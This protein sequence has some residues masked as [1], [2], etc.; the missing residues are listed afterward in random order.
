VSRGEALK[1]VAV[2]SPPAAPATPIR[3]RLD[4]CAMSPEGGA[5]SPQCAECGALW[6]PVDEDRWEAFLTDDKPPE[7]A[8][9]CPKCAEREFR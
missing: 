6:P 1:R 9:Y 7:L 2:L 4:C 3:E 8:F 5:V